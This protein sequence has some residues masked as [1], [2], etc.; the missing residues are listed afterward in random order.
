MSAAEIEIL[1]NGHDMMCIDQ[2]INLTAA[3]NE[4]AHHYDLVEVPEYKGK[5]AR[6]CSKLPYV[7]KYFL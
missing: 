3:E 7:N 1:L 4:V 2:G 5:L 6:G